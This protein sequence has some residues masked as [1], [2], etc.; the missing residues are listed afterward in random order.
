M[1]LPPSPCP[2]HW[3]PNLPTV[4]L[5]VLLI[6]VD[7]GGEGREAM[8]GGVDLFV[9]LF[10]CLHFSL[11]SLGMYPTLM[12]DVTREGRRVVTK[13]AWVGLLDVGS[14]LHASH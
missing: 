4:V 1:L 7:Y 14:I 10:F 6:T 11:Y 13:R 5:I 3:A 12:R 8:V 9:V 2:F